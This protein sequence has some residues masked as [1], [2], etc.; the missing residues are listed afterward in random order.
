MR[1]VAPLLFAAAAAVPNNN[2]SGGVE[3]PAAG[4]PT[5]CGRNKKCCGK[6]GDGE[7]PCCNKGDVC[8][9]KGGHLIGACE[10]TPPWPPTP[11][12]PPL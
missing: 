3:A 2:S 4:W 1:A 11:P 9:R 7:V 10:S 8:H 12:G 6:T 5:C